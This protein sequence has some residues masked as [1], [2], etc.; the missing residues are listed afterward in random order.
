MY[1]KFYIVKSTLW[2]RLVLTAD[3]LRYS[4][5]VLASQPLVLAV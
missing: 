5:I 3:L 2:D 1:I 4:Y